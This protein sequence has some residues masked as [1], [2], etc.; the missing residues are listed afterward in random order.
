[1]RGRSNSKLQSNCDCRGIAPSCQPACPGP[2]LRSPRKEQETVL[3]VHA[4]IDL[5]SAFFVKRSGIECSGPLFR[6]FRCE[7]RQVTLINTRFAKIGPQ[8][9]C[10]CEL[11]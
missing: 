10:V 3:S 1:M 9:A 2:S 8:A 7:F 11:F 6:R 4:L 5:D